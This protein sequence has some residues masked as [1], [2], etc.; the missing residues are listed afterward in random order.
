MTVLI[1][2]PTNR[3]SFDK[4]ASALTQ[5]ARGCTI[6][7][8]TGVVTYRYSPD[9]RVEPF[10]YRLYTLVASN[11]SLAVIGAGPDLP[12][13]N[14]EGGATTLGQNGGGY[15]V[16]AG[17]SLEIY[18]DITNCNGTGYHFDTNEGRKEGRLDIYL[19]HELSHAYHYLAGNTISHSVI[20]NERELLSELE[21]PSNSD[22]RGGLLQLSRFPRGLRRS[23]FD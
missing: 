9:L 19:A 8:M 16:A 13:P 1:V 15:F 11:V 14:M 23:V 10:D 5:Y 18:L 4:L 7:E 3:S 22:F 17:N 12:I 2:N 21:E 20:I 6:N